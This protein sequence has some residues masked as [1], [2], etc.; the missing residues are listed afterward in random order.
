MQ[1]LKLTNG[2]L[3]IENND[4]VLIDG[5]DELA[6][7]CEII[8]G[9]KKQEWFLNPTFGIDFD[10]LNG[11]NVSKEAAREQVRIGLRQEPRIATIE[12]IDI[13]LDTKTRQSE[14][15]FK[16][17]GTSGEVA[18]GGTGQRRLQTETVR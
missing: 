2:D 6:Q 18:E 3:T 10:Q 1:S 13:N 8:L 17:M 15:N 9:T 11:K 4:I 7:C 14:V 5:G 12:T 16:A